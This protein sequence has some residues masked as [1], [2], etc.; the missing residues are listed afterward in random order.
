MH[1]PKLLLAMRVPTVQRARKRSLSA[2]HSS[3][4]QT[5]EVHQLLTAS[6]AGL[7]I[8]APHLRQ[9]LQLSSAQLVTTVLL[10]ECRFHAPRELTVTKEPRLT[11][12]ALLVLI[13]TMDQVIAVTQVI[14]LASLAHKTSIVAYVACSQLRHLTAATAL[15]AS[16]A[17]CHQSQQPTRME[18]S[19]L[20]SSIAQCSRSDLKDATQATT[21]QISLRAAAWLA[22]LVFSVPIL[23]TR[24]LYAKIHSMQW[25][26]LA[27]AMQLIVMSPQLLDLLS[28]L[29][30][31]TA[32]NRP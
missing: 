9:R 29:K 17:P 5:R 27:L 14:H 4:S 20:T 15:P 12:S 25:T 31:I 28:A 8:L 18:E 2:V 21:S 16:V 1:L 19:A 30:V 26:L 24:A 13:M 32:Q 11:L 7:A 6:L 23:T 22:L 10:A 3:T